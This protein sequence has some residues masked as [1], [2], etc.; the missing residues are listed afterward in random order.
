M[1]IPTAKFD[2]GVA[3]EKKVESAYKQVRINCEKDYIYEA[4]RGLSLFGARA[5]LKGKGA[6][7][8]KFQDEAGRMRDINEKSAAI[9]KI[10]VEKE[11]L[12]T[13]T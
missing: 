3:K 10:N 7:H 1:R 8:D 11:Y 2:E 12:K 5:V 4:I 13:R 9:K 6:D